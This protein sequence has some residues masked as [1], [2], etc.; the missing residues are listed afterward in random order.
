VEGYSDGLDQDCA[1]AVVLP[2]IS[3]FRIK[4]AK[5]KNRMH[6]AMRGEREN[7]DRPAAVIKDANFDY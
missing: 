2:G 1:S 6:H 7:E 3:V 5:E 4:A